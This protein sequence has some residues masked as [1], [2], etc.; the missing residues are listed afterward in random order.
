MNNNRFLIDLFDTLEQ[1]DLFNFNYTLKGEFDFE[2][3]TGLGL[4]DKLAE[5]SNYVI[6]NFMKLAI[7]SAVENYITLVHL[8]QLGKLNLLDLLDEPKIR[9]S[10]ICKIC[11]DLDV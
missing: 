7:L 3:L 8:A 11:E 6:A 4:T 1:K 9:Y 5:T 10:T 2:A